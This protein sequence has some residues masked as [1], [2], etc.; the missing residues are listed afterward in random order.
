MFLY[1]FT[2][3]L[4]RINLG[5]WP[6][7]RIISHLNFISGLEIAA[8]KLL[9]FLSAKIAKQDEKRIQMSNMRLQ[10]FLARSDFNGHC[11]Y[12]CLE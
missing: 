2:F 9:P 5:I 3:C 8:N 10:C 7:F 1:L 6:F 11:C 12:E 4:L